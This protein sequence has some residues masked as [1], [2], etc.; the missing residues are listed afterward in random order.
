MFD[1]GFKELLI[2]AV[3]LILLFGSRKIPALAQNIVEAV[4]TMR[5][6]FTDDV[7][8]TKKK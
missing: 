8:S 7:S 1:I 6:G 3:I 4:K 2:V 5:K